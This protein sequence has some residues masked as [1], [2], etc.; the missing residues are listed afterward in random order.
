MNIREIVSTTAGQP[1]TD[2]AGVRM[3]R[4]IGTQELNE[5]KIYLVLHLKKYTHYIDKNKFQKNKK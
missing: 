3:T 4:I 5:I 1:A 2:G